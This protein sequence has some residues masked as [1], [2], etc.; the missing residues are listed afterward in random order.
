MSLDPATYTVDPLLAPSN[1]IMLRNDITQ[2]LNLLGNN[3]VLSPDM[4]NFM[5][6]FLRKKFTCDP[7]TLHVL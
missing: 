2:I 6:I 7:S 3:A 5:S 1:S 4:Q